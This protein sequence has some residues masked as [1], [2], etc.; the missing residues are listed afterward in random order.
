MAQPPTE[1]YKKLQEGKSDLPEGQETPVEMSA[2]IQDL[3]LNHCGITS[4]HPSNCLHL[5]GIL[6]QNKEKI[7]QTLARAID[8]TDPAPPRPRNL[9]KV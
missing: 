3:E 9:P 1:L 7:L 4:I 5:D 8:G 2:M 6:P